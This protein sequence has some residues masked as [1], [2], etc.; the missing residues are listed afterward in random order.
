MDVTNAEVCSSS[1]VTNVEVTNVE[2]CLFFVLV[3]NVGYCRVACNDKYNTPTITI[4]IECSLLV[5]HAVWAGKNWF[6]SQAKPSQAKPSQVKV[7]TGGGDLRKAQVN[8]RLSVSHTCVWSHS[9][10]L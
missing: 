10:A 2:V 5:H 4:F 6:Y 3:T 1:W 7:L 8:V 9:W